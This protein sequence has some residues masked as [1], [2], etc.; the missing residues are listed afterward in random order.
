MAST[1][2][3]QTAFSRN[4]KSNPPDLCEHPSKGDPPRSSHPPSLSY[5]EI[6]GAADD[7]PAALLFDQT[8][9]NRPKANHYGLRQVLMLFYMLSSCPACYSVS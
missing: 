4:L 5:P 1:K 9:I 3:A 7:K 8:G 6:C 2:E